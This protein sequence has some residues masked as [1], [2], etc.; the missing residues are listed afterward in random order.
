MKSNVKNTNCYMNLP[1]SHVHSSSSEFNRSIMNRS[2]FATSLKN[3]F[4]GVVAVAVMLL[5]GA[6]KSLAQSAT[7]VTVTGASSTNSMSNNVSTII[8]PTLSVVSNGNITNFRVQIT[9]SYTNGDVVEYLGTLPAG[10]TVSAFNTGTR[11]ILFTGTLTA[12]QWTTIL[13]QVRLKT[14]SAVC[15][16]EARKIAFVAGGALYNPFNQNC[17]T[18]S[19]STSSWTAAKANAAATSYF[20]LQGYLATITSAAENSFVTV[21]AG[22]NSWMGC[23]DNFSEINSALGY[24]L[25]AN[26]TAAE[27]NW[28]W[29]TGPEKGTK[30]RNGNAQTPNQ[31]AA[32][33]GIYQNWWP[34]E[35][36][37]WPVNT[38]GGDED[39]GHV[40]SATDP[41]FPS[42]WNDF[43]NSNIIYS[44]YEFGDTPG[45]NLTS[46]IVFVKM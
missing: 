44:V 24:T 25:F 18:I 45:D 22:S 30:I 4:V 37:D 43:S 8:D 46:T 3:W 42:A 11:S 21:I 36:N 27:G 19:P 39:Y 35:P 32:V 9:E 40:F 34:Q 6:S 38:T 10:V 2:V 1:K 29:V 33:A 15:F 16:P 14:A 23:S 20:G 17:Y 7:T 12:Q 13:Q 41:S 5:G 31:G 28:Y 26:Q